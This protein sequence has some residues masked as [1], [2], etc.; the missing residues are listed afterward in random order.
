MPDG[1][2]LSSASA[3]H[4]V[5]PQERRL[6]ERRVDRRGAVA[7]EPL[8]LDVADDPDNGSPF[9]RL[10]GIDETKPFTDGILRRE[11]RGCQLF[12]DQDNAR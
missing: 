4:E 11:E 2:R 10:L 3:H 7:V 5:Q 6:R 9:V 1:R 8:I 12:V